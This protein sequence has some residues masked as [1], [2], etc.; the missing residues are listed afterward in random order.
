M[1]VCVLSSLRAIRT[2]GLFQLFEKYLKLNIK[3]LFGVCL[4]PI[5]L[6][7]AEDEMSKKHAY[8][9]CV[10][11]LLYLLFGC[12]YYCCVIEAPESYVL[13]TIYNTLLINERNKKTKKKYEKPTAKAQ[14]FTDYYYYKEVD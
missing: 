7:N 8:A 10:C 3:K 5:I 1:C 11:V 4:V 6:Y 2:N 14:R 13:R 9:V 12:C